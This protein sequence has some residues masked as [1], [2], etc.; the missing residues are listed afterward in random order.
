MTAKIKTV[1]RHRGHDRPF[2]P[3]KVSHRAFSQVYWPYLPV[4]FVISVLLP[5]GLKQSSFSTALRHPT[6]QVLAYATSMQDQTLLQDTNIERA[7]ANVPLLSENAQLDQAA[8][9]KAQD[10]ATR[11]YWSH[12]TPDGNPPWVFVTSQNY[13]YQKLGENLATGFN[14]E[15]SAINGWMGSPHP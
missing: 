2:R 4:I 3:K 12:N 8:E 6:H 1:P 13:A 15:Q 5:L 7:Q 14:N 10:M 11:D 9:T